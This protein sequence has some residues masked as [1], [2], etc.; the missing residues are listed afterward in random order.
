MPGL[1][2]VSN[3][4][5]K[6]FKRVIAC[7]DFAGDFGEFFLLFGIQL[8]V[9][10]FLQTAQ[11]AQVLGDDID[12]VTLDREAAPALFGK[13]DALVFEHVYGKK[14]SDSLTHCSYHEFI[15]SFG[16]QSQSQLP[17]ERTH[18]I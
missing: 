2:L 1:F 16:I 15:N 7:E 17:D 3:L 9:G 5:Q 12:R 6:L 14:V 10:S 4:C 8:L 11:K 18:R 13:S